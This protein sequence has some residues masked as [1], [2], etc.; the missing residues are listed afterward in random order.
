MAT[1]IGR[2]TGA[3]YVLSRL[4]R[5]NGRVKLSLSHLKVNTNVMATLVKLSSSGM[6]QVFI[7][8]AS[9]IGLM[10]ILSSY[11]STAIAGCDRHRIILFALFPS[12]GMS[13]AAAT[14]VG[15]A[16]GAGKPDRAEKAVWLTGFYNMCFLGAIGLFFVVC[17]PWLVSFFSS[18]PK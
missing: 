9:W 11:G 10:R 14:M 2:G 3:L 12:F 13:N 4:F 1:T 6:F 15:Q 16:L 8:M 17:S 5:G 18:G 7:G